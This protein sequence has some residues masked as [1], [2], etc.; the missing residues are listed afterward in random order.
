MRTCPPNV[1]PPTN[2]NNNKKGQT[3]PAKDFHHLP[4][5]TTAV[6]CASIGQSASLCAYHLAQ[7]LRNRTPHPPT[8]V[9]SPH[10]AA[11]LPVSFI[12]YWEKRKKNGRKADSAKHVRRLYW[13]KRLQKKTKKRSFL[14]NR[15]NSFL[16]SF[17]NIRASPLFFHTKRKM[18]IIFLAKAAPEESRGKLLNCVP[19]VKRPNETSPA[20]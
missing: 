2:N 8:S 18:E 13:W 7:K 1:P 5:R 12:Y 10:S 4:E 15:S 17:P 6:R 20:C 19:Y 16:P 3:P 14:C 11:P 9:R